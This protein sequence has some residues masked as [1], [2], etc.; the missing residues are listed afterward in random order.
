MLSLNI[1][2]LLFSFIFSSLIFF[3]LIFNY[4]LIEHYPLALRKITDEESD[5]L[6]SAFKTLNRV[7]ETKRTSVIS[8]I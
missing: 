6:H 7:D 4:I 1:I 5:K 2:L 3:S 8:L